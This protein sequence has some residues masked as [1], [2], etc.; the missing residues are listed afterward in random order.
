VSRMIGDIPEKEWDKNYWWGRFKWYRKRKGGVWTK[1]VGFD[2]YWVNRE[3]YEIEESA[4]HVLKVE[5]Y[6]GGKR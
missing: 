3:P 1:V 6:E 2:Y 4:N 5:R